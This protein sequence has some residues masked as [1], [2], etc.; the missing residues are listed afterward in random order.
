MGMFNVFG[1]PILQDNLLHPILIFLIY[2][3]HILWFPVNPEEITKVT[4]SQSKTVT[5][6]NSG[7]RTVPFPR[8]L[9]TIQIKSFFYTA[10]AMVTEPNS[11][12]EWIERWRD[13]GKPAKL[14]VCG[15]NFTMNV[16]CENFTYSVKAGESEDI[17][18]TLDLKEFIPIKIHVENIKQVNKV[19]A[20]FTVE[21]GEEYTTGSQQVE[22][23]EVDVTDE[24]AV[25][26]IEPPNDYDEIK[27]PTSTKKVKNS[28]EDARV[29]SP[30]GKCKGDAGSLPN[31]SNYK[32]L[33]RSLSE[34]DKNRLSEIRRD[35]V[36]ETGLTDEGFEI[37]KQEFGQID[38]TNAITNQ[39]NVPENANSAGGN[40]FNAKNAGEKFYFV[41][42]GESKNASVKIRE[43]KFW[44]DFLAKSAV[45]PR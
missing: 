31:D 11:A 42:G 14:L 16:T 6:H 23:R 43:K 25:T 21:I 9:S 30:T 5:F 17:Y 24:N 18:F 40:R 36:G 32:I 20:N 27:N 12:V 29:L 3:Y 13:S 2:D 15:L 28:I 7:E 19:K 34:S 38:V 33:N 37:I 35:Y 1:M 4:K 22:I 45:I 10:F 41:T 26:T 39:M 44:D 8:N